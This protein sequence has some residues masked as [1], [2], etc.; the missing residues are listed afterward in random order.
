MQIPQE[1][2]KILEKLEA[3]NF[4]A[5]IVGGCVRDTLLE[6]KPK[7]W[8]ITTNAQPNELTTLFPESYY[9]N[10]Y[11]T[12]SVKTGSRESTLSVVEVTTYRLETE[13]S[14][15][16]HPDRIDFTQNLE[17]DLSRRDFT[18]NAM[19]MDKQGIIVDPFQGQQDLKNQLIRTVGEPTERFSEDALRLLR[20]VRLACQ[21]DFS[22]ESKTLTAI[23]QNCERINHISAERIRD[24]LIKIISSSHPEKGFEL[25][26]DTKLLPIILPEIAEGIGVE[27]N[28][29]HT[30]TVY[31]HLIKSLQFAADYDYPLSVRL[32]ALFHDVGKPQ[33]REYKDGDFTF[34]GHDVVSAAITRRCLA[35][36]RFPKK[37]SE[38]VCHLVRHHMF[39]YDIGKVTESGARRLL[40]RVGKEHFDNLIKLRI[41]ER[42][43]S[44][45]PKA[46]PYRLRHL[47]FLVEKAAQDPITSSQLAISGHDL[48]NELQLKPGP[49]LG[50]ILNALLAEVLD[51]PNKNT[52]E[53][54][55][56][57]A[58]Q[59][60]DKDPAELKKLGETRVEEEQQKRDEEIK[61][62]YHVS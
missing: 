28:K 4:E 1:V 25:M 20:A 7:D 9:N 53:Y 6:K 11:A 35:R 61:K 18:V 48:M 41:S 10:E 34:Y 14:D 43:G 24:E 50:G 13:Y 22:I 26:R 51:D 32:A 3:Q 33:T 62:K 30:Y 58:S 49:I 17:D 23:N 36:L 42:K 12:V 16:R 46:E 5:Y 40:R 38:E 47:Q 56:S 44:G 19:A 31:E 60:K 15:A 29:H 55:L 2:K 21:L 39:Y 8:D 52:R 27:Q 37:L 57:Q 45:V 59:M 54:L